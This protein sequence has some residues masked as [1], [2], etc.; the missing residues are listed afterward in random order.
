M[1]Q[2]S[3][4]LEGRDDWTGLSDAIER[5][6]V[7]NRL[8]QR[9]RPVFTPYEAYFVA[10]PYCRSQ[11]VFALELIITGRRNNGHKWTPL[12]SKID[13]VHQGHQKVSNQGNCHALG[14]LKY[15]AD[16]QERQHKAWHFNISG[17]VQT[18]VGGSNQTGLPSFSMFPLSKDHLIPLVHYNVWRAIVT[19]MI[20]L[21]STQMFECQGQMDHSLDVVPLPMS[22]NIPPSLEPTYLQRHIEH[23]PW[24]DLFPLAALRDALILAQG[25]YDDCDL[26]Y[27]M[28]GGFDTKGGQDPHPVPK[29]NPLAPSP[30][31]SSSSSTSS[32]L[33][34][35]R[36]ST[37]VPRQTFN[38]DAE[39]EEN[40]GLIIW[41]NPEYIGSW[42]VSEGF[43]RKWG[44]MISRGCGDLLRATDCH[45]RDRYDDPIKWDEFGIAYG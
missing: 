1:P 2:L 38:P 44:W 35:T 21:G 36:S 8:N 14:L 32:L 16:T 41:G 26:C 17:L 3:E 40:N 37:T 30:S 31:P 6:K 29:M 10:R 5:R 42:E 7:Q 19:N 4:A 9:A 45:R 34:R 43:A 24:I 18:T 12:K 15:K 25:M 13:D 23:E 22:S 20:L 11:P 28:V 39:T 33:S 27:D